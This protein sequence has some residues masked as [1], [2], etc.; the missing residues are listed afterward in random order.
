MMNGCPSTCP[1][2]SVAH[3]NKGKLANELITVRYAT[4]RAGNIYLAIHCILEAYNYKYALAFYFFKIY[5]LLYGVYML[6]L[7]T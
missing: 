3:L 2:V 4:K 1:V 7:N 5:D 6:W